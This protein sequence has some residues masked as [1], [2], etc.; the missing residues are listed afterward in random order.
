MKKHKEVQ[1]PTCHGRAE[2]IPRFIG[3]PVYKTVADSTLQKK[4]DDL[5]EMIR[6]QGGYAV[7]NFGTIYRLDT[8][9]WTFT[10]QKLVPGQVVLQEHNHGAFETPEEAILHA[11]IWFASTSSKGA[12]THSL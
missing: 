5:L 7:A 4:L 3:G 1:C 6:S 11:L 2:E 12:S 9:L 8:G 10:D